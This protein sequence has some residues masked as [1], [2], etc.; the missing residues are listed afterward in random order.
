MASRIH[1]PFRADQT[2]YC[3]VMADHR[4]CCTTVFKKTFNAPSGNPRNVIDWRGNTVFSKFPI[5]LWPYIDH[6]VYKNKKKK[7]KTLPNAC[8]KVRRT[9]P[10]INLNLQQTSIQK[11]PSG[12][13]KNSQIKFFAIK[14]H[15][16]RLHKTTQ[17]KHKFF[18]ARGPA[19][20]IKKS[21]RTKTKRKT[22]D[23]NTKPPT[24]LQQ[25]PPR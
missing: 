24:F 21:N 20:K 2:S 5:R 18:W 14:K 4:R 10:D 7:T 13:Q 25:F 6:F 1:R 3:P 9:F 17:T 11:S 8:S 12:Q 22:N 23:N 16:F 19:K 15:K